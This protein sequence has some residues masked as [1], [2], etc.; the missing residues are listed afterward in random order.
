MSKNRNRG[1]LNQAKNSREYSILWIEEN[2]PPYWDDGLNLYPVWRR[3]FKNSGK[4]IES[5]K[6]RMYRTWKHNRKTQW[7]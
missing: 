7:K 4:Q 1:F 5:Y 2:Y 6:M 3:G